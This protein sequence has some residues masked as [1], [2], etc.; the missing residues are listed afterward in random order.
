MTNYSNFIVTL[1]LV[2]FL[3]IF[4]INVYGFS[5]LPD[6]LTRLNFNDSLFNTYH[7]LWV[8]SLYLNPFYF[9]IGAFF[10]Y[11]SLRYENIHYFLLLMCFYFFY[12]V[13]TLDFLIF[14]WQTLTINTSLLQ[15]NTLLVNNLNK[16]HPFIFYSGTF[17]VFS[18]LLIWTLRKLNLGQFALTSQLNQINLLQVPILIVSLIA[19][20]LGSWWA[21]QEGTWGG[22]WNWDPSETFGLL[23]LL[24]AL[25]NIH[26]LFKFDLVYKIHQRIKILTFF[27]ILTYFFIQLNFDLVSHNF[28]VKFFYFFNNKLFFYIILILLIFLIIQFLF[29]AVSLFIPYRLIQNL[30]IG[31]TSKSLW[32]KNLSVWFVQSLISV[33]MLVSFFILFNYFMWNFIS[34]NLFNFDLNRNVINIFFILTICF[35]VFTVDFLLCFTSI[36]ASLF[37]NNFYQI[38]FYT[39]LKWDSF[40]GRL[41]QLFILFFLLNLLSFNNNFILWLTYT[42][43]E[44]LLLSQNIFDATITSFTCDC[45][46]IEKNLL[47]K[48]GLSEWLLSWNFFLYANTTVTNTFSLPFSNTSLLNFYSLFSFS[49]TAYIVIENNYSSFLITLTFIIIGYFFNHLTKVKQSYY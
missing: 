12:T 23:F 10:F 44:D 31:T 25:F 47:H 39:M 13:E 2:Y 16:I 3:S 48:V 8:T 5:W 1:F 15:F 49:N 30:E 28:G 34:F 46:F 20:F 29:I 18:I 36:I 41:H 9:L 4:S 27:L 24:F 19:L 32:F 45:I 35:W 33:T 7:F 22:W 43:A 40:I 42:F 21:V 14:N 38:I 6:T 26:T 17:L 37:F 11:F